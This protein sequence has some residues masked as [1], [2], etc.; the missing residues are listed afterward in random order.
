MS[1]Q[2]APAKNP[3]HTK[4]AFIQEARSR[5]ALQ[6][7]DFTLKCGRQSSYF[8]NIAAFHD[9]EGLKFLGACY[10][11]LIYHHFFSDTQNT[12]QDTTQNTVLFGPA[13]KGIPLVLATIQYLYQERQLNIPW[14]FNRKETKT[15]GEGGDLVG[16]PIKADTRVIVVDDVLSAGTS[17]REIIEI[18][19]KYNVQCNAL[20]IALDRNEPSS[21]DT[22]GVSARGALEGQDIK[23]L[24]LA[25]ADDMQPHG[26]STIKVDIHK[27]TT[28][29][30]PATRF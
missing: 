17:M 9:A 26:T 15:H 11:D 21:A 24:S 22:T 8:F 14:A 25:S 23:V 3:Q 10:G 28:K 1:H 12:K 19:K 30:S 6:T 2:D 18:L 4:A 20:V 13:Y 5:Q 29:A 16:A 27:N 7:G